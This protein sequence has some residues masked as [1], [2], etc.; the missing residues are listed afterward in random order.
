M[1]LFQALILRGLD[2]LSADETIR[3]AISTLTN[4]Y[5]KNVHIAK[6]S[7]T[8]ISS[9]FGFVELNSIQEATIVLQILQ[10]VQPVFEIDGKQI[11]VDY[12]KNNYT[13]A[14]VL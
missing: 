8:S 2:A 12:S 6:D 7:L 1:F 13:T 14:Y 9:G 11:N 10:N 4:V 5:P 3:L